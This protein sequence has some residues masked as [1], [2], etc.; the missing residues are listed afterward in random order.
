MQG[1]TAEDETVLELKV[2]G[3]ASLDDGGGGAGVE[4]VVAQGVED[5]GLPQ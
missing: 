3:A 1:A 2:V 5:V 4:E